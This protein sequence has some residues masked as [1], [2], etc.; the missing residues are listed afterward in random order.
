MLKRSTIGVRRNASGSRCAHAAVSSIRGIFGC[1][2][3]LLALAT[4]GNGATQYTSVLTHWAANAGWGSTWSVVDTAT[5][6][7]SCTL[8][9]NDPNGQPFSLATSAG[10]GSSLAF[11]VAQGGTAQIQAGGAAGTLVSGW[12]E[13]TCSDAFL[14]DI[15]YVYMPGGFPVTAVSVLPSG[16][17]NLY[18]FAANA[19][20]GIAIYLP[21]S[22]GVTV[23]AIDAS[24]KMVGSGSL[25]IPAGGETAA[26]LDQIITNIPSDFEGS[27]Q[28]DCANSCALVALDVLPGS[29]G[30]F[31]LANVPVVAY[32]NQPSSFSGTY[33]FLSGS[34]SGQSGTFTITGI[35][36]AGAFGGQAEFLATATSGSNS[37]AMGLN[38]FNNGVMLLHFFSGSSFPL[39]GGEAVLTQTSSG[40]SG[41]LYL[42][43]TSTGSV[44]TISLTFNT[45]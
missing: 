11:T 18:T 34:L 16:Q 28:V 14:A 25:S 32:N 42:Q 9:I 24:G 19:Y 26:N 6:A 15:T 13:V 38:E 37:T 5:D 31:A 39:S 33:I 41:S 27:V 44:G 20:T 36:P 8:T 12:S 22:S 7:I 17:F 10:T 21:G 4:P 29:N 40:F 23:T 2:V 30:S 3:W 43:G 1:L 45:M 35:S